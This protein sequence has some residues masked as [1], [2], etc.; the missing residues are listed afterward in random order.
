MISP[1]KRLEIAPSVDP[2]AVLREAYA[3]YMTQRDGPNG[4]MAYEDFHEVK[5][6]RTVAMGGSA[7][8][9]ERALAGIA[10]DYELM[11]TT[12]EEAYARYIRG[13]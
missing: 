5:E 6:A 1:G 8:D 2:D 9:T 11:S 13:E 4:T 7:E 12:Q 10:I 3:H